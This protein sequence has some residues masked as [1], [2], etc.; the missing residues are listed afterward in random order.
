M[1][2][3][4][5]CFPVATDPSFTCLQN[6]SPPGCHQP[7]LA[8]L[9]LSPPDWLSLHQSCPT[10]THTW[11]F[12]RARLDEDLAHHSLQE[13]TA[14]AGS[15]SLCVP[16]TMLIYSLSLLAPSCC[17]C[18]MNP[19]NCL[20]WW[21]STRPAFLSSQPRVHPP[22]GKGSLKDHRQPLLS[23]SSP[24]STRLPLLA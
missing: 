16:C 7:C 21:D 2:H 13:R 23:T 8:A 11:R 17:L 9:P 5:F 14:T 24:S 19:S 15:L 12:P 20:L 6:A 10:C 4:S 18:G 3:L 22:P 1:W